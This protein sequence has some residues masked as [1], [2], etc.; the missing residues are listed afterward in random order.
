MKAGDD[1]PGI[2]KQLLT[3]AR[4][5]KVK[6]KCPKPANTSPRLKGKKCIS[7]YESSESL[8]YVSYP[9]LTPVKVHL[10]IN[11]QKTH[12]SLLDIPR[13]SPLKMRGRKSSSELWRPNSHSEQSNW[14]NFFDSQAEMTESSKVPSVGTPRTSDWDVE[15]SFLALLPVAKNQTSAVV[16]PPNKDEVFV[17]YMSKKGMIWIY[18]DISHRM[19]DVAEWLNKNSK[20]KSKFPITEHIPKR[21]CSLPR[22][23]KFRKQT[24]MEAVGDCFDPL[25]QGLTFFFGPVDGKPCFKMSVCAL[26][27]IRTATCPPAQLDEEKR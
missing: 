20:S 21:E 19:E 1:Q 2:S 10:D 13:S 11:D 22:V 18:M 9:N 17:A 6:G 12:E 5:Q 24:I 4:I 23:T 3:L 15:E 27:K 7:S 14:D 16:P 26:E 8:S 25:K